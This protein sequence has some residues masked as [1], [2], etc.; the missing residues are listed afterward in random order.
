[1]E[2]RA[3]YNAPERQVILIPLPSHVTVRWQR[4]IRLGCL[5]KRESAGPFQPASYGPIIVRVQVAKTFNAT[6]LRDPTLS[7]VGKSNRVR[8]VEHVHPQQ[9]E[10]FIAGLLLEIFLLKH[11]SG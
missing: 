7:R 11:H 2:F 1:M 6:W 10:E 4:V 8:R 5:F 3:V 9:L